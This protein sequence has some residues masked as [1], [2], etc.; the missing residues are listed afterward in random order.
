MDRTDGDATNDNVVDIADLGLLVNAY[1]DNA[2]ITGSGYDVRADFNV[3]GMVD[4]AD[5]GLLVKN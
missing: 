1:G 4:I 3:D 2:N 5:F